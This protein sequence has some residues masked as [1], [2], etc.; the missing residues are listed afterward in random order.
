M[1]LINRRH[2]TRAVK[3][4]LHCGVRPS[5]ILGQGRAKRG[6]SPV[7]AQAQDSGLWWDQVHAKV[8]SLPLAQC[9]QPLLQLQVHHRQSAEYLLWLPPG[10]WQPFL[11][12]SVW[13]GGWLGP[14]TLHLLHACTSDLRVIQGW[15]RSSL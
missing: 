11:R 8:Q 7:Q 9:A 3:V 14:V 13:A 2:T 1:N 6:C 5:G 10:L 12:S 15:R 4:C